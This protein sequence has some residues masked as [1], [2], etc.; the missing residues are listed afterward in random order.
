MA[1]IL[2]VGNTYPVRDQ[3]KALG[4]RWNK[5]RGGWDVPADAAP[6]AQALIDAA[7]PVR[8]RRGRFRSTH[9]R[10]NSGADVFTNRRGRCED[11]PCCGCCS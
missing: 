10:F 3:I 9:T 7:G 4:G 11:A 2:I 1:T 6:A 5:A 8:P